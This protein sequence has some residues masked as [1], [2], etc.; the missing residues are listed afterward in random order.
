MKKE[1][2]IVPIEME[3]SI[4]DMAYSLID[5]GFIKRTSGYKQSNPEAWKKRMKKICICTIKLYL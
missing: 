2:G 4:I 5:E 1:L 3:K